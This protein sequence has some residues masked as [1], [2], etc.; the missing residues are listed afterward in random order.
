MACRTPDAI[1][2]SSCLLTD[3]ADLE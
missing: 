1:I 2:A 3:P